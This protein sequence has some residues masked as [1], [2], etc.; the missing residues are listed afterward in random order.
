MRCWAGV[1]WRCW[2]VLQGVYT[3][4]V[5]KKGG[6]LVSWALGVLSKKIKKLEY[7][8]GAGMEVVKSSSELGGDLPKAGR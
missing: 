8:R 6:N 2:T 5:L 4:V 1:L 3:R 7:E